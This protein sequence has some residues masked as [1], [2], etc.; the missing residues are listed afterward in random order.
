MLKVI[1]TVVCGVILYIIV[2]ELSAYIHLLYLGNTL[3]MNNCDN[4]LWVGIATPLDQRFI[5]QLCA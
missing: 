5:H 1:V 3:Y 4:T 2:K